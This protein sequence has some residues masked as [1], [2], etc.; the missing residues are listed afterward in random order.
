VALLVTM[1]VELMS[2][3]G[4][5][6]LSALYQGRNDGEPRPSASVV[7]TSLKAKGG[8]LAGGRLSPSLPT[9]PKPSLRAVAAARARLRE[10]SREASKSPSNVLPMRPGY[11]STALPEG[12]SPMS[13]GRIAELKGGSHVSAF[14]RER[15]ETSSGSSL[16]AG[17]LRA[18]YETWCAVHHHK[19]LSVPKF[20]AEL[21]VLGYEKWKSCGLIRYRGLRFAA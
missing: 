9:L 20:A 11:P 16:G 6:G 2:C 21:Q 17:E 8:A 18:A 7:P 3:C 19:P 12:A 4:L 14:V 10:T 13:Q 15:L 5:A 1:V